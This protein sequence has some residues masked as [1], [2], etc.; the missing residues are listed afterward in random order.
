MDSDEAHAGRPGSAVSAS[1]LIDRLSRFQGPPHVFL[2]NLLAVQCQLCAASA[3]AILRP[4]SDG[5]MEVLAVYPPQRPGDPAPPWL[6]H[7]AKAAGAVYQGGNTTTRP[8]HDSD[9]LY[10]APARRHLVMI[11]L[12][13]AEGLR[14][15]TA[16]LVEGSDEKVAS[17]REKLELTISLLSLYEMRLTLQRRQ[18]DLR[19]LRMAME[20]LAAVN[21][22]DRFRGMAMSLCNDLASRWRCERVGLGFLKGRYIRLKALSHVE[23]FSRKMQ[24]VQDMES[25]MEECLDQDVEVVHPASPE[26]TYVSRSAADL[27]RRH[28]PTSVL[29]VPLRHAGKPTAVLTLERPIDEPFEAEE[30]EAIRLTCNLTTPRL[31]N[32]YH[33]DRW[34]GARAAGTARKGLAFA[35][36][37][38]HTWIK[39]AILGVLG[40]AAFL[41]FVDGN[42]EAPG[43]FTLETIERL[44]IP[45]PYNG[46]IKSINAK[47]GDHVIK[48]DTVLAV[49]KTDELDNQITAALAE[50]EKYH[51]QEAQARAEGKIAEAFIHYLEGKIV[52]A[53]IQL[54]EHQLSKARLTSAIDGVVISEDLNRRIGVGGPVRPDEELFVVAPLDALRAEVLI[55]EDQI[56]DI[57]LDQRGKL[58]AASRPDQRIEFVV[59]HIGPV[60]KVVNQ[61]N[62]FPVRVRLELPDGEL[63]DW[64]KPGLEGVARVHIGRMPYGKL[65]T[66]KMVNWIRMKLWL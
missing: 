32:R 3:G 30:V 8:I 1:D 23:K 59:E 53:Q 45:A 4:G 63:L 39:L 50:A 14:G 40:M 57:K 5:G 66:R 19:R 61:K 15:M 58:A 27:S 60:A 52:A 33:Q 62:V 25:A 65:W 24:I 11:P 49:L 47:P 2:V 20:V 26:A 48:D 55:G 18:G 38:K 46:F 22:Q 31:V 56:G 54:F 12:K 64:M 35:V 41:T 34:F 36:G 7:A 16:F 43:T 44:A 28:G 10:G 9:D 29:S 37:P 51:A 21:E 42:Y 13:H 17:S 6:A